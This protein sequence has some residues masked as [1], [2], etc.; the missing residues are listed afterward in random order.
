[1]SCRSAGIARRFRLEIQALA[2]NQMAESRRTRRVKEGIRGFA[3]DSGAFGLVAPIYLG[4]PGLDPSSR[5][6]AG[7]PRQIGQGSPSRRDLAHSAGGEPQGRSLPRE[8]D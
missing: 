2:P 1:M 8:E 5:A 3:S 6:D 4:N 7:I